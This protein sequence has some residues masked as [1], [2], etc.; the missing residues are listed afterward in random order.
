MNDTT[1]TLALIRD[2]T[3]K[4]DKALEKKRFQH[5]ISVASTAS[6]LAMR[7]GTDAYQA[8]LAGLLHDNAKCLAHE[9]KLS[10]CRKHKVCINDAEEKNPDLLH[11]K[12]GSILAKEKYKIDDEEILSAIRWHTT[13]KPGMTTLEKIIYIADYME[14][15]RKKQP[16][17]DTVRK[18]AFSDLDQCMLAI[19]SGTLQY[20]NEKKTTIDQVTLETYQFYKQLVEERDE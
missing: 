8:Y 6:C 7:Y 19:L 16:N 14:P 4:M 13:G 9:K 11:A 20:L 12:A 3:E 10:V 18:L 15:L 2:L 1:E 5:T 17:M